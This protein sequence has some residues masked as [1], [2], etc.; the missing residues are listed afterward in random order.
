MKLRD[1]ISLFVLGLLTLVGCQ[2]PYRADQGALIGGLGGA[3]IGAIVGNQ[4]G[5]AGAGAVIGGMVGT[6][7][8]ATIG[9]ELDEIA[10]E[11]QRQ[12]EAQLGQRVAAGAVSIGDV[13]TMSQAG[14]GEELIVTHVRA[15]GVAQTLTPSDL[16]AL[17][18]AGVSNQVIAAM[19]QPPRVARAPAPPVII[20]EHHYG[21]P[22]HPWHARPHYRHHNR[23][24]RHHR[25]P[26]WNFGINWHN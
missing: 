20:E 5:D 9:G 12:I 17:N 23:H 10:A 18:Q 21:Y 2:S 13:I 1:R 14:V 15:N 8:G 3:G 16:I 11:N 4:T 26:N 24:G 22:V 25:P 19:Q 7:A 6:M